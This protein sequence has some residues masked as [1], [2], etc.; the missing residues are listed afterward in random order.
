MIRNQELCGEEKI[1][2]IERKDWQVIIG[3]TSGQ[4][5]SLGEGGQLKLMA[6]TRVKIHEMLLS[7]PQGCYG[8]SSS[9][10]GDCSSGS[11]EISVS[12]LALNKI[13]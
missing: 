8:F 10:L 1:L 7:V 11:W 12:F 5:S 13:Q 3:N 4:W 6:G 9:S 2:M